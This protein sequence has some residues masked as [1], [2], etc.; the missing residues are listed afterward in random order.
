[1]A[2]EVDAAQEQVY[3]ASRLRVLMRERMRD[4]SISRLARRQNGLRALTD[5]E[6]DAWLAFVGR[7][8]EFEQQRGKPRAWTKKFDVAESERRRRAG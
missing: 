5:V 7:Q 1:M 6:L 4:D 8:S 2:G 3:D